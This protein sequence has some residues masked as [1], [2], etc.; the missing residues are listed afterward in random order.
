[1]SDSDSRGTKRPRTDAPPPQTTATATHVR[2]SGRLRE[3]VGTKYTK[4]ESVGKEVLVRYLKE[5][6]DIVEVE[7]VKVQ[8]EPFGGAGV[9]VTLERGGSK[10]LD[11]KKAL[12]EVRGTSRFDQQLFLVGKAGS[13]EKSS[14]S[15]LSEDVVLSDGSHLALCVTGEL[16]CVAF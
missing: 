8:V 13:G 12:E 16:S 9:E 14:A 5:R 2:L 11:L 1:M 4:L 6:G 15:P 3:L 7:L 10:G